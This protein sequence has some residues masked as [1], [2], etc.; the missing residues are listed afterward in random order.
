MMPLLLP[1]PTKPT[2]CKLALTFGVENSMEA[3]IREVKEL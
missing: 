2:T 3:K 1:Y